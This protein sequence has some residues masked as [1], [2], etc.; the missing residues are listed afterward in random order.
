MAKWKAEEGSVKN[1]VGR[2]KAGMQEKE[3]GS[4]TDINTCHKAYT[5]T[6][7]VCEIPRNSLLS[8][9]WQLCYNTLGLIQ[10]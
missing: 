1:S 6:E 5:E 2:L 9:V 10:W 8:F 4:E 7:K 3:E